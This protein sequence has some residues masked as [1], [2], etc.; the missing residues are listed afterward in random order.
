V[1]SPRSGDG[2]AVYLTAIQNEVWKPVINAVDGVCAGGGLY[3]VAHGDINVVGE[4]ATFFDPHVAVGQVAAVE[5]IELLAR[6]SLPVVARMVL[7][8]LGERIDAERAREVGLADEVVPT[9]KPLERAFELAG[10]ILENSPTTI[11]RSKQALWESID[12]PRPDALENAWQIAQ[13]HWKHPDCREGPLA[14]TEKRKPRWA[15]PS[16]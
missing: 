16:V 15:S 8:G 10:L 4:E 11:M 7:L 5:G 2:P 12:R 3:F 13:M 1:C 14:F 9:G 6:V